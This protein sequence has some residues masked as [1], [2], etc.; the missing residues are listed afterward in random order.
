[1]YDTKTKQRLKEYQLPRGDINP[2]NGWR[3]DGNE[4][5]FTAGGENYTYEVYSV[6]LDNGKSTLWYPPAGETT[7]LYKVDKK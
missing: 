5:G 6:N 2:G 4:F 7:G 1:L 3:A